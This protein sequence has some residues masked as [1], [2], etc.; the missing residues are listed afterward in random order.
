[1]TEEAWESFKHFSGISQESKMLP[2]DALHLSMAFRAKHTIKIWEKTH[3]GAN[4]ITASEFKDHPAKPP[5]ALTH[6]FAWLKAYSPHRED[7]FSPDELDIY[8]IPEHPFLIHLQNSNFWI[9]IAPMKT[10]SILNGGVGS[11]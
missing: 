1:M 5:Y 3:A 11:K 6:I 7:G 10:L 8:E 9:T 2:M 4:K